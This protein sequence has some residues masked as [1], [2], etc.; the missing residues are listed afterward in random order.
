MAR[1]VKRSGSEAEAERTTSEAC[2][3]IPMI[4]E[5]EQLTEHWE[6]EKNPATAGACRYASVLLASFYRIAE[7]MG[8]EW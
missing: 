3:A 8:Y 1:S 7:D 5:L 6:G 2:S 4:H